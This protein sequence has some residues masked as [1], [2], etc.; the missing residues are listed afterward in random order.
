[1]KFIMKFPNMNKKIIISSI[2]MIDIFQ[3]PFYLMNSFFE[4]SHK[5]VKCQIEIR[6][7]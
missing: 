5:S 3:S 1:M 7:N 6:A 4:F 2:F